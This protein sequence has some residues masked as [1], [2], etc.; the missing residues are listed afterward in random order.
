MVPSYE[1]FIFSHH[2]Y[3]R[4]SETQRKARMQSIRDVKALILRSLSEL[5]EVEDKQRAEDRRAEELVE[6]LDQ[7]IVYLQQ[8]GSELEQISHTEDHLHLLQ[9]SQI[10]LT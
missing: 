2:L 6:R 10:D 3:Q 1:R 7:A 4:V 8:R 9:V 5:N